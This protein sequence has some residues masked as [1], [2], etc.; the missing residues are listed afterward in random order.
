MPAAL[1][2]RKVRPAFVAQSVLVGS[3]LAVYLLVLGSAGLHHQD[4]DPY[5]AAGRHVWSGKPLYATFLQHPFPDPTLRPAFIYPP[6]FALLIAPL[7]LL[8]DALAGVIWLLICQTS[9]IAALALV[10]RW[11]KPTSWAMTALVVAT[12]TF[13]PLWI[14]VAQGQANLPIV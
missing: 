12:F 10:L 6:A 2:P 9:L 8:P 3:A 4:L 13:Y 7:A 14:D 1:A 5:L 11:R